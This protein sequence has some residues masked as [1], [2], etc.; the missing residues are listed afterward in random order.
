MTQ[1]KVL[2][3][4]QNT[5]TQSCKKVLYKGFSMGGKFEIHWYSITG[6]NNIIIDISKVK[7][8]K[9]NLLSKQIGSKI[10]SVRHHTERLKKVFLPRRCLTNAVNS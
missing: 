4:K 5:A 3:P 6:K 7:V 2:I 10:S 8:F 1:V 9:Q